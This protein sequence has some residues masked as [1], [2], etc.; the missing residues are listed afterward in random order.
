[1][2]DTPPNTRQNHI[3]VIVY[4]FFEYVAH[5]RYLGTAVTNENCIHEE[6]KSRLQSRDVCYHS[7]YCLFSSCLLCRNLEVKIY[8]TMILPVLLYGC[9]TYSLTLKEELRM[10][11]EHL[12]LSGSGGRLEKTA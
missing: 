3:L 1:V 8:K 2:Y 6:I 11:G 7:I 10:R 5:F 12:D 9:E 4:K